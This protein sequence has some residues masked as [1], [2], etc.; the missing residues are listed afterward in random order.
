MYLVLKK[1]RVRKKGPKSVFLKKLPFDKLACIGKFLKNRVEINA[2][3]KK[4]PPN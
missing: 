4:I 2:S 3:Y 1:Y